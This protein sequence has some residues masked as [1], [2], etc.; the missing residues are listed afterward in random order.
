MIADVDDPVRNSGRS[1]NFTS[2]FKA[3]LEPP[4][5]LMHGIDIAVDTAKINAAIGDSG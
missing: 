3:P 5:F 2:R 1:V 4:C